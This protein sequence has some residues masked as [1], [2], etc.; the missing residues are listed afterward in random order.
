M[1]VDLTNTEREMTIIFHSSVY[2]CLSITHRKNK[3]QLLL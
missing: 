3:K 1:C 2:S